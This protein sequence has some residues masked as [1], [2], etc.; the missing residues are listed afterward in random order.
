MYI[1]HAHISGHYT[2]GVSV[3]GSKFR[4]TVRND[5]YLLEAGSESDT[6]SHHVLICTHEIL[7]RIPL[8]ENVSALSPFWGLE[9]RQLMGHLTKNKGKMP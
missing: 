7:L 4:V 9:L 3:S 8:R 6:N 2:Y 5:I 1:F